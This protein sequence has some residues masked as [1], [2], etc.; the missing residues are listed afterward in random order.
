M[1]TFLLIVKRHLDQ[2]LQQQEL[3]GEFVIEPCLGSF[4]CE[5][6][7]HAVDELMESEIF[8]G[9]HVVSGYGGLQHLVQPGSLPE[10]HARANLI[11][12]SREDLLHLGDVARLNLEHA[13]PRCHAGINHFIS[14]QLT[15][16][17]TH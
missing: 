10:H 4:R 1:I 8:M 11:V 17:A 5:L 15:V 16:F 2:E 6:G 7:E 9:H 14:F 12:T 13:E 3:I